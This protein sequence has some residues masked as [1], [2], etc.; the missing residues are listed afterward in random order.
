[1]RQSATISNLEDELQQK[2]DDVEGLRGDRDHAAE[3]LTQRKSHIFD[4]QR[5]VESLSAELRLTRG[6]LEKQ[7]QL[8]QQNLEIEQGN[9]ALNA[10]LH[11]LHLQLAKGDEDARRVDERVGIVEAELPKLREVNE[12]LKKRAERSRE[13]QERREA[14]LKADEEARAENA[15]LQSE[16]AATADKLKQ[17]EAR[18]EIQGDG[19]RL[20]LAQIKNCSRD[21]AAL[22]KQVEELQAEL[23]K[24][25]AAGAELVRGASEKAGLGQGSPKRGSPRSGK[26]RGRAA[27]SPKQEKD[28]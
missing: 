22:K 25:H 2:D 21:S 1:V 10:E 5:R 9:R 23:E 6:S 27:A 15:A 11:R 19:E 28:V 14:L 12:E 3:R 24:V 7:A 17:I 4:L 20:L 13:V 26:R 18:L 8:E 16:A